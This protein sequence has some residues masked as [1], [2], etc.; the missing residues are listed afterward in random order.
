MPGLDD[1]KYRT[2]T[3][4]LA[5][6]YAVKRNTILDDKDVIRD[7]DDN[8]FPFESGTRYKGEWVDNYK[9]GFGVE[10]DSHGTKYEG[11]W[12][13]GRYHG[14]GTLWIIIKKQSV[15]QYEGEWKYG[16][17]DG[18]GVYYYNKTGDIYRGSFSKGMRSGN[19]KL[20][21]P[22][23]DYYIG[24]WNE[25][26][27]NGSGSLFLSNGNV[28]E[29]R[30]LHGQ[31]EG[32]GRFF[33]SSTRKVY[34][35]EWCDNAPTCGQYRPPTSD[36]LKSFKVTNNT[37]PLND[38]KIPE[39]GLSNS[40]KV[41]DTAT[42]ETRLNRANI[43]GTGGGANG[44]NTLNMSNAMANIYDTS[45]QTNNTSNT[46]MDKARSTFDSLDL[47][48]KGTIPFNNILPVLSVLGVVLSESEMNS[49]QMEL[50]IKE[51]QLF[52]LPEIIDV[53]S[54]LSASLA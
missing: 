46:M 10:V 5:T 30:W 39:I 12:K 49:L 34:E 6:V 27:E 18:M 50:E 45:N 26:K 37:L 14:K 17:M 22:N 3:G 24:E 15:K 43:R 54:F 9:D 20:E 4:K 16:K 44:M 32:P 47:S 42:T 21:Y 7:K 8:P 11:D 40:R 23:G 51:S 52:S 2:R 19:G 53:A 29:G 31:K 48:G 1:S 33:Y 13:K 35:G 28:Y 25:D 41:I 36:E 38:F